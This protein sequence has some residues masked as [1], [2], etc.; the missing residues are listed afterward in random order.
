MTCAKAKCLIVEFIVKPGTIKTDKDA[1]QNDNQLNPVP[2]YIPEDYGHVSTFV[3][4]MSVHMMAICNARERTLVSQFGFW[5]RKRVLMSSA[6]AEYENLINK[7]GMKLVK[8]WNTR[9]L[10]SIIEAEVL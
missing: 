10:L 9:S 5:Y 4:E 6:K 2:A 1:T 3:H 8:L 7:A